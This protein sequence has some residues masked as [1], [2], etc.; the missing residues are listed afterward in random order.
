MKKNIAFYVL[1]AFIL[2]SLLLILMNKLS[3]NHNE[4][5]GF[6]ENKQTEIN[7]DKDV[8]VK[9]IAVKKGEKVKKGQLLMKVSNIDIVQEITQLNLSI[10]GIKIKNDLTATEIQGEILDLIRQKELKLS[11]I[12]TKINA[13]ESEMK[14]YKE[15][16][17]ATNEKVNLQNHPS[18]DYIS[19]LKNEA[20][21][22]NGQYD[23]MIEH[24]QKTLV[25]PKETMTQ[26]SMMQE[27]INSLNQQLTMFDVVA[28]YDGVI[29]NINVR[30][31]EF[32]KSFTSMMSFYESTP[33]YVTGYIQEKYDINIVSGDSV[34][35]QS[36]YRPVNTVK[37]I[38]SA[39]GYRII[40][41]PEKFRK[42]PDVKL[43]GV[44]VFITIPH[45]NSF[46]QNEILKISPI[47][48]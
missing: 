4:F 29:G 40:E 42:I 17:S 37:G 8:I 20:E 16:L 46:L 47:Q 22:I 30:Q 28:P 39:K 19:Q 10:A 11:E 27:K 35:I 14:F 23:Q 43:Y 48:D 1:M 18:E 41:I 44:E 5:F 12:N 32:V 36:L 21:R 15:L 34:F 38:I 31:D 24:Y 2:I 26:R 6:A 3:I 9:K 7:L 33:P 13:S 45:T 25:Q